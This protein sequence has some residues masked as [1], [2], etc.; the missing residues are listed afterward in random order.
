MTQ[1]NEVKPAPVYITPDTS[2]MSIGDWIITYIVFLIPLLNIIMFFYWIL[3][4]SANVNRRNFLLA[5]LIIWV[6]L[7]LSG[8][9]IVM[10]L[11]GVGTIMSEHGTQL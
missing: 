3:S 5:S 4:S 8:F 11:G 2:P 10:L 9:L 6:V 1:E 7:F